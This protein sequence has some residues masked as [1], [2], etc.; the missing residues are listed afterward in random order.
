MF[1]RNEELY[2]DADLLGR[3]AHPWKT[4]LHLERLQAQPRK[5]EDDALFELEKS[6]TADFM[7]MEDESEMKRRM[8][9][10]VT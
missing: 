10:A 1:R 6:I 3:M 7:R 2:S 4:R 5:P 8:Q 9:E